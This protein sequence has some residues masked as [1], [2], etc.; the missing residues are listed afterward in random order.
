[1]KEAFEIEAEIISLVNK[2]ELKLISLPEEIIAGRRNT[3][4]RSIRQ[5]LG[6]LIDSTSNNIHRIVH[7]QYQPTPFSFP[8]YA[9]SGNN[10]RWIAIQNYQN[11]DWFNMIQLWKYSLLHLCHVIK[12]V[13]DSKLSNEWIAGPDRTYTLKAMII[14]FLK[15]FKLHLSEINDLVTMPGEENN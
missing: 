9:S 3:Q 7:L 4:N 12:N 13:N 8:N 2:W 15:H 1:M 10:D 5:I 11:E 6:H 14:D